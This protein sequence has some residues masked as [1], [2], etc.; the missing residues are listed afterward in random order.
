MR[1]SQ[2][3]SSA[4][5]RPLYLKE[6]ENRMKTKLLSI[7]LATVTTFSITAV[8]HSEVSAQSTACKVTKSNA[9]FF[10]SSSEKFVKL[11]KGTALKIVVF[12]GQ[13]V[14]VVNARI[15]TK[16]VRGEIKSSDTNCQ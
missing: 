5:D 14:V 13:G 3:N 9:E 4:A 15:G 2:L 8:S 7:V 1:G 10:L 11:K 6:N 12:G 16:W